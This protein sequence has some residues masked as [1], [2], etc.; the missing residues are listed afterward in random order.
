ML[1]SYS[2]ISKLFLFLFVFSMLMANDILAQRKSKSRGS[3]ESSSSSS[4]NSNDYLD[5]DDWLEKKEFGLNMT[6]II[7]SFVPFNL[8]SANAGFVGIRTKYYGKRNSAVRFS[9]GMSLVAN[10]NGAPSP[11]E[12]FAYLSIGTEKRKNVYGRWTYTN[13]LDGF[14]SAG[15]LSDFNTSNDNIDLVI[16]LA[17]TYGIEYNINKNCYVGTEAFLMLGIGT[18]TFV[19]VVYPQAIFFNFR[20]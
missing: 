7:H 12:Q 14:L 1:I 17:K 9:A 6:T 15:V 3:S 2:K 11:E 13:G 10:L 8:G 5:E 20:F 4:R 16:G 18:T 19:K